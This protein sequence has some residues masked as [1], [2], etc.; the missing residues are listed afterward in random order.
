MARRQ[1]DLWLRLRDAA[2]VL[3]GKA[4]VSAPKEPP[5]T[6]EQRQARKKR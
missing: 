6:P 1:R 3:R 5:L 4:A 2:D